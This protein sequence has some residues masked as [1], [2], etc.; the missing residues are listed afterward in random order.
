MMNHLLARLGPA[1][2]LRRFPLPSLVLVFGAVFSQ[3]SAFGRFR[4]FWEFWVAMAFAASLAVQLWARTQLVSTTE[5]AATSTE[6]PSASGPLPHVLAL[7]AVLVIAAMVAWRFT[8]AD[9]AYSTDLVAYPD[10]FFLLAAVVVLFPVIPFLGRRYSVAAFWR[11]LLDTLL[12]TLV[13]LAAMLALGVGIGLIISAGK[14]LLGWTITDP[15]VL[16]VPAVPWLGAFLALGVLPDDAAGRSREAREESALG[17]LLLRFI[18]WIVVP[19]LAIYGIILNAYAVKILFQWELPRGGVGW[20]VGG[21]A[22]VGTTAWLLAQWPALRGDGTRPL[23]WFVRGWWMLLVA[24]TVLLIIGTWR[25]IAD[26]G[27]TPPRYLLALVATWMLAALA[28]WIWRGERASGRV[29]VGLA[30]AL[31]LF[32]A[33]GGP[34]GAR[35]LSVRSQL[36]ILQ[37]ALAA[38]GL[39]DERGGLKAPVPPGTWTPEQA[40]HLYSVYDTLLELKAQ[41]ALLAMLRPA[42]DRTDDR[43][44]S[45]RADATAPPSRKEMISLATDVLRILEPDVGGTSFWAGPNYS[46]ALDRLPAN[47]LL[48]TAHLRRGEILRE[49]TIL[50]PQ[51]AAGKT[52]KATPRLRLRLTP[53]GAMVLE[54]ATPPGATAQARTVW[55]LTP[56]ALRAARE[57]QVDNGRSLS[58]RAIVIRMDDGSHLVVEGFHLQPCTREDMNRATRKRGVRDW[59]V[60]CGIT[61][62]DFLLLMPRR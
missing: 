62:I 17:T 29:L 15:L 38:K 7:L 19:L 14:Y 12:A 35:G 53:L 27:L 42:L 45:A 18:G 10:D 3:F 50:H 46:V 5:N 8:R 36:G 32:G 43:T 24:P 52:A 47:A 41:D 40:R 2:V 26:Y 61:D 56:R 11:F 55:K 21:L 54:R 60:L 6:R 23:R 48:T 20:M 9:G 25:R 34:L 4:F 31:L 33:L 39:L 59:Q 37:S 1:N 49:V 13:C 57:R 44:R 58:N 30:G 51:R 22:L 16:V 28:L